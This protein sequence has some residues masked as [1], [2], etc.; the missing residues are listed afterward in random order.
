MEENNKIHFLDSNGKTLMKSYELIPTDENIIKTYL[1]EDDPLERGEIIMRLLKTLDSIED[2]CSIVLDAPWGE[3]KTFIIK[4]IQKII[5]S[6]NDFLVKDELLEDETIQKIKAKTQNLWNRYVDNDEVKLQN[7]IVVYFDAWR[8]DNYDEPILSLIYSIVEHFKDKIPDLDLNSEIDINIFKLIG[9]FSDKFS[10]IIDIVEKTKDPLE[11]IK[12]VKNLSDKINELFCRL[13][14][15][16]AD[17]L[18]IFID[19]LD[20]C[21][22]TFAVKMLE[23]IKH[24]FSN[25]KITFVFAT[26]LSEL[27]QTIKTY[28]GEKYDVCRYLDRFFDFRINLPKVDMNKYYLYI[29]KNTEDSVYFNICNY[30]AKHFKLSMREYSRFIRICKIV[31]SGKQNSQYRLGSQELANYLSKTVFIPILIALKMTDLA[32][33]HSFSN[34]KRND[35]LI[36]IFKEDSYRWFKNLLNQNECYIKTSNCSFVKLSDRLNEFYNAVFNFK[37]PIKIGCLE[38]NRDIKNEIIRQANMI[39]NLFS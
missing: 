39:T 37:K 16:R 7:Q 23:R 26:N 29:S 36:N 28:Y 4:Q 25:D 13:L 9:L 6:Y 35:L 1:D 20:R 12:S 27:S 34:G 19:E 30:V 31:F 8:N 5:E 38:F 2:N 33:Y 3:G 21:K 10:K 32:D 24:Y 22:P 14:P 17:R 11:T 15:E 18:I